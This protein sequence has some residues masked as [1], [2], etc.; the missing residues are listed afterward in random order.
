ML[1]HCNVGESHGFPQP[2]RSTISANGVE[3]GVFIG[4]FH[5]A[6]A[7]YGEPGFPNPD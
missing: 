6:Q 4:V 3:Y 1:L 5:Q 2:Q 7:F